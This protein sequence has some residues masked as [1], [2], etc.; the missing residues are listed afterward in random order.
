VPATGIL[1]SRGRFPP[2]LAIYG[3]TSVY[4]EVIIRR[5]I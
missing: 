4:Y 5:I 3:L 1:P 2:S